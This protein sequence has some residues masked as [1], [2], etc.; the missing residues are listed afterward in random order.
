M[1]FVRIIQVSIEALTSHRLRTVLTMLGVIF[2]VA[3][4]IAMLSIGEG[5][6]REALEQISILGI[7]NVIINAKPPEE[8]LVTD[9]SMAQ[10]PGLSLEDG[11]NI[12]KFETMIANVVPQRYEPIKKIY[13]GSQEAPVR[14]VA[15]IPS[16]VFSTSIEVEYGRFITDYD[17]EA[18]SEV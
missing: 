1:D 5:A 16:Y 3:A 9:F 7:N 6:K 13:Y 2:G 15:T 14:V 10:S 17:N 12:A 11:R 4:V 18:F 8:G